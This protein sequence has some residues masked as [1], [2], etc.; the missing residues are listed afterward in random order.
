V[1]PVGY[2][3]ARLLAAQEREL[4]LPLYLRDLFSPKAAGFFPFRPAPFD[5]EL[6]H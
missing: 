5:Q 3:P 6:A 2:K 4:L 1:L